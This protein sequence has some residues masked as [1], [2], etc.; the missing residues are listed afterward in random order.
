MTADAAP[1][2]V[3]VGLA[4]LDV[5]HRVDRLAG[6]DEKVTALRQDV[7]AGGPATGAAL[8]YA[9]LGGPSRLVTVL[10]RSP[11][12]HVVRSELE[13]RGVE[14]LDV[15]P[16]TATPVPV[17]AVQVDARTGERSITSADAA[18]HVVAMDGSALEILDRALDGAAV[19]LLDGHHRGLAVAA[20]RRVTG[21]TFTATTRPALVLDA[22]RWRP[23][24]SDLLGCVDV[25]ICSADFRLAGIDAD[26]T[27]QRLRGAGPPVVVVTHGG[28]PVQ[29]ADAV[30]HG[31]VDVPSV[32]VRDT[33]GAGDAFHG[34]YA[35][36][37]AHGGTT[38]DAIELA[39]KVASHR[40]GTTGPR[41]WL[42]TLARLVGDAT[43]ARS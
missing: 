28:E 39:V 16:A 31:E 9:A 33:S 17:S 20:A 5:V 41:D 4:T 43:A 13:G 15:D 34:A 1:V 18:A 23:V 38:T 12:A 19:V 26:P 30:S 36:S 42:D 37:L 29:W 2:G 24:M 25:A 8:T 35:W 27:L 40:V 3:F 7:A 32:A 10:G 22:G 11:L 14:V 21:E 6:P